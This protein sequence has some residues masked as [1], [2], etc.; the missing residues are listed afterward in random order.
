MTTESALIDLLGAI[1]RVPTRQALTFDHPAFAALRA[2]V[3]DEYPAAGSKDGLNFALSAALDRL[4]V[5]GA[6]RAGAMSDAALSAAA[7]RL[8]AGLTAELAWR[9]HLCPLDVADELPSLSFGPNAVREFSA[10]ALQGLFSSLGGLAPTVD[11]RF[12]QFRWLVVREE[13]VLEHPPGRRAFP[14]LYINMGKDFAGIE[15][16]P[17]HFPVAV[18]AALFALLLAPWEDLVTHGD[19][20]WRAFQTPWVY[21]IDEDLFVRPGRLPSA[22]S[23]SWAPDSYRDHDGETVEYE[24]P[25][26]YAWADAITGLEPWLND[27]R[28]RAVEVALASDLFST[29][30]AHFLISAFSANGID[31]FIGHLTALEAALGLRADQAREKTLGARVGALLGDPQAATTY[32]RLF[33]LRSEYVHGRPMTEISGADRND[34][35]RLARRVAD[36]LVQRAQVPVTARADMLLAL[37]P[38][39]SHKS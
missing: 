9:T 39:R 14:F 20:N 5:P 19:I 24:R 35:R 28:W 25:S 6:V 1:A 32:G 27:T 10:E 31:E 22:D 2:W 23:L 21:T 13:A 37:A 38:H 34:A 17:R 36:G 30:V 3:Q 4:G 7:D 11:P 18:E 8:T 26:T 15:P 33:N 12:A 29:P 16:H